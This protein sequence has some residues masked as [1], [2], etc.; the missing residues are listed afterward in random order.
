MNTLI[1]KTTKAKLLIS[2]GLLMICTN[3]F[4]QT[5]MK[6]WF[7]NGKEIDFSTTTPTVSN[8]N[9]FL[10]GAKE[11]ANAYYGPENN[12]LISVI[13]KNV[14]NRLGALIGTIANLD[15]DPLISQGYYY[16]LGTE[17]SIV[18]NPESAC[19]V[20]LIYEVT[21]QNSGGSFYRVFNKYYYA[22]IDLTLNNGLGGFS[23]LSS[24]PGG[25]YRDILIPVPVPTFQTHSVDHTYGSFVVGK[26]N[27]NS[28]NIFF[29]TGRRRFIS[30]TNTINSHVY[31]ATINAQGISNL[32][33]IYSSSSIDLSNVEAE[34]SHNN[35]MLAVGCNKH[36]GTISQT[37]DVV[38]FHL[39]SNGTVN[40]VSTYNLPGSNNIA[41]TGIEFNPNNLNI[42]VGVSGIGLYRLNL[43]N[44]ISTFITNSNNYGNSQIELAYNGYMYAANSQDALRA[45]D[46]DATIPLLLPTIDNNNVNL[47][48][49]SIIRN[50]YPH[51]SYGNNIY[52]LPQQ[53]DGQNYEDFFEELEPECCRAVAKYDKFSYTATQ[54][55]T[56]TATSNPLNNGTGSV[57]YIKDELFIP[58]GISITIVGMTIYF[59]DLAK[60]IVEN[61][62]GSYSTG[63]RL[64][65]DNTT[66]TLDPKCD[67]EHLWNGV[68]VWGTTNQSQ[69]LGKYHGRLTLEN[70]SE[71]SY[72]GNAVTLWKYLDYTKSGGVIYCT[73]S[74]FKNNRRS[75]EFISYQNFHPTTL[76]PMNNISSINFTDFYVDDD[77][78]DVGSE[79]YAH[80]T[81]WN[82]DGVRFRACNFE[83]RQSSPVLLGTEFRNMGIHS[84]DA[85]YEV[86]QQC[87]VFSLPCLPQN[88]LPSSFQ[89][90][91][92]G[93]YAT[94]TGFF[95][96]VSAS[97]SVFEN[98]LIGYTVDNVDQFSSFENNFL[99]GGSS[100]YTSFPHIGLNSV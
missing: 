37:Q 34:L 69:L 18:P 89:D 59:S 60:V 8:S 1:R 29:V 87:S 25:V 83:N 68:E 2:L 21:W 91:Y 24:G 39:N 48:S 46:F 79:F 7:T 92:L 96:S 14:Y 17:L 77:Y 58:D 19:K 50:Q 26:K 76:A 73:N 36:A 40:N 4:A 97:N 42:I 63:G 27:Q 38:L 10:S 71:I 61:G 86:L 81:L 80:A 45:I 70:N 23:A 72:A 11:G 31:K 62:S 6:K 67:A 56:W 51:T 47:Q 49:N 82:V 65:L 66:F 20:F 90:L 98:N 75:I 28:R 57:A 74:T 3:S 84:I 93:I 94:G 32:S 33:Q 35:T 85:G 95:S 55:A 16:E 88:L 9:A 78:I 54:S 64:T 44:S 22:E 13:D 12:L 52:T 99:I 30:G 15:S 100:N 41:V 43:I 5:Q 53:I